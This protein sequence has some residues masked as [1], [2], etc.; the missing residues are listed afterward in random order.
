ML[1]LLGVS[2]EACGRGLWCLLPRL[3]LDSQS[4]QMCGLQFAV[5]AQAQQH[6]GPFGAPHSANE[7]PMSAGIARLRCTF[8]LRDSVTRGARPVV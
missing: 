6:L 7:L 4:E 3:L 2:G 1:V 5:L 8:V